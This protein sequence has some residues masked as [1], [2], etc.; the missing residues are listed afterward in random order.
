MKFKNNN[1]FV[2]CNWPETLLGQTKLVDWLK[3]DPKQ[4]TVPVDTL[5]K[6]LLIDVITYNIKLKNALYKI[7]S[8]H[9]KLIY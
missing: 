9:L 2:Y 1:I 3:G 5:Y 8:R 6:D 4:E 7:W